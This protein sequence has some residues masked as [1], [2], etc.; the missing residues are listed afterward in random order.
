MDDRMA[1]ADGAQQSSQAQPLAPSAA[2]KGGPRRRPSRLRARLLYGVLALFGLAVALAVAGELLLPGLAAQRARELLGRYGHVRAVKVQ[3]SPALE[4]LFGEA[5]SIE[6]RASALSASPDQLIALEQEAAGV[7]R[8][9]LQ[10]EALTLP[11][12]AP[13]EGTVTLHDVTL[14]KHGKRLE[15]AGSVRAGDVHAR[16]PAGARIEGIGVSEGEPEIVLAGGFAGVRLAAGVVVSAE[17]GQI[18][19]MPV[20]IPL[21]SLA[22]LSL[23][24]NPGV[25]FEAL[26]ASQSGAGVQIRVRARAA[27]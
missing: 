14:S 5:Q 4:L 24:S 20:G 7:G 2:A 12:P 17:A 11:L 9:R 27:S 18:V 3:A 15:A 16:L 26:S 1:S 23:L 8:G 19:G 6:A 13:L 21:A 25:Y 10:A 22:R